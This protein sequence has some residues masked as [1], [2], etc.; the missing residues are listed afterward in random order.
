MAGLDTVAMALRV[1][2]HHD[3]DYEIR[4]GKHI[5]IIVSYLGRKQTLVTG[6]SVSD[7]RAVMNFYHTLRRL[8]IGMGVSFED[9]KAIA[10]N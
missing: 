4:Q 3:L 10:Y 8:L 2:K 6:K 9:C 1:L 7:N 5:K